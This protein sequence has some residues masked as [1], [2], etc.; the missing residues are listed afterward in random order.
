MNKYDVSVIIPV[1]NTA[2]YLKECVDSVLLQERVNVEIICV[3]DESPDNSLDILKELS[4]LNDNLSYINQKNTGGATAINNGLAVAT[5]E[6]VMILDS[7]DII[8]S[9]TLCSLVSVSRKNASDIVVGKVIR[10]DEVSSE[11]AYDT[12]W[13]THDYDC[14]PEE[15]YS[16]LYQS[17]VYNGKLLRRSFLESHDIKFVGGLLYADRPFMYLCFYYADCVSI[18]D[19]VTHYWRQRNTRN[20]L[21]ITD[22]KNDFKALSDRVESMEITRSLLQK[23]KDQSRAEKHIVYAEKDNGIRPLWHLKYIRMHDLFQ[24][25]K[26]TQSYYSKINKKSYSDYKLEK[27]MIVQSLKEGWL[28]RYF[29]FAGLYTFFAKLELFMLNIKTYLKRIKTFLSKKTEQQKLLPFRLWYKKTFFKYP[30]NNLYKKVYK[31]YK[32]KNMVLF[33]CNFGKI[34]GG[35][36]KYLYKEV[37]KSRPAYNC[38][39]VYQGK[40]HQ[41]ADLVNVTQVKRGSIEFYMYLAISNIWINNINFPIFHKRKDV[42]YLQTW[43]GTPIKRLGWDIEVDGPE[44]AAR[45]Q[46][47]YESRNWSYML[48][49]NDYASK[50]FS[51]AFKVNNILVKGYPQNDIFYSNDKQR[52]I[53]D[54]GTALGV[55]NDK[56]VI[57]YAPTWRDTNQVGN[58]KFKSESAIN[59]KEMAEALPDNVVLLLREHH[60]VSPEKLPESLKNKIV[61][62]SMWPDVQEL[63]LLS[64]MLITD[65]SSIWFDFLNVQRPV[66][67]YLYDHDA[68]IGKIRG[69]YL[70]VKID[71]PGPVVESQPELVKLIHEMIN[72]PDKYANELLR[73]HKKYCSNDDGKAAERIVDHVLPKY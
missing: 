67:F 23:E 33:E 70:N 60:L 58:W 26:I 21:S 72:S 54:V 37:V 64:D 49:Q 61:D 55:G 66:I 73:A 18:V 62:V 15:E 5:G 51:S 36:P 43:H 39:W 63:M 50:I 48:A 29:L 71:L 42:V 16:H 59:L 22:R 2:E 40:K 12:E 4:R 32:S 46:Q 20:N 65:Y 3:N 57:L 47:Y 41:H 28:L 31:Q 7:D 14:F 25:Y 53:N 24:F 10:F 9:E 8:P 45:M 6:F 17:G 35:M 52:I 13:I 68:Y 56:Y 30:H 1:Y 27:R 34:Y 69:S 19:R 11:D 38:I 44:S